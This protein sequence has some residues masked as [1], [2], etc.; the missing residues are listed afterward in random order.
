[1]ALLAT[2]SVRALAPAEAMGGAGTGDVEESETDFIDVLEL[3]KLG[4]NA[5]DITK[6]KSG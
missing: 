1:M 4:I 2:A 6:L 5:A 3:Q